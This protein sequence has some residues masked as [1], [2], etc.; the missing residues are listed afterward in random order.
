MQR[1]FLK[2]SAIVV[3]QLVVS[4]AGLW[5]VFHDPQKRAEIIGAV[6]E[7]AKFWLVLGFVTYG[8]VEMLAT[9]RWRVL[10]R[11]QGVTLRIFQV[12]AIVM[13]GLFLNMF[14]PGLIGG[15]AMR[16]YLGFKLVPRRKVRV[17]LSV[18]MDRLFG[19]FSI[20][21][22]AA[23]TI[24][25]RLRWFEKSPASLHLVFIALGL[26]GLGFAVVILLLL[27]VTFGFID[28]L[29]NRTPFRKTIVEAGEAL[30]IYRSAPVAMFALF[31]LTLGSHLAYYLTY[32]CALQSL[33]PAADP[34][35]M[36]SSVVSIIPVVNTIT[37][38][39][40]S[41]GGLGLREKLFQT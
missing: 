30:T 10:L 27:G 40:V 36:L 28:K 35:K 11:I 17:A 33:Q 24:T 7:S 39:P 4:V 29:P 5:F 25:F 23:V 20:L 37:S 14:L 26:L 32:Y 19:L 18:V 1:T 6:R 9:L 22:L 13:V 34:G 31:L 21:F 41:V 12:F 16:L 3:I 38:L 15:D 8:A 2:R